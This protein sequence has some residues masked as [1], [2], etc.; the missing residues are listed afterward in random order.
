M[1][2][3]TDPVTKEA[4]PEKVFTAAWIKD[5]AIRTPKMGEGSLYL[6]TI[7]YDPADGSTDPSV[8]INEI[9]EPLWEIVAGVPEA[10]A[11][12]NAFL[13][14]MESAIPAILAY[15]EERDTEE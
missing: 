6:E 5:F 3:P 12:M 15:I 2:I 1:P 9:R 13:Q 8:V 4:I 7:G 11:V 14:G 10:A